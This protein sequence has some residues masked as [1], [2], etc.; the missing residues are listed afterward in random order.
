MRGG[1]GDAPGFSRHAQYKQAFEDIGRWLEENR[2]PGYPLF[3][4][5]TSQ[6]LANSEA[7]GVR[8]AMARVTCT[9]SNYPHAVFGVVLENVYEVP[10]EFLAVDPDYY[11]RQRQ[12]GIDDKQSARIQL[13]QQNVTQQPVPQSV[14]T[15]GP[16]GV[17]RPWP[18]IYWFRAANQIVVEVR[19]LVS[20]PAIVNGVNIFRPVPE[21]NVTFITAQLNSD[22][23]PGAAPGSTGR[24]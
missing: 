4:N 18:T 3:Y 5:E 1:A 13:T 11:V 21:V 17:W 16:G 20:Y 12:G 7:S 22:Y 24:P 2:L 23:F 10:D 15:G 8:G 19:R 6:F 14:F 9:L